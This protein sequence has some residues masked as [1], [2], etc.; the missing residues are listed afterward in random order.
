MQIRYLVLDPETQVDDAE[1]TVS[2]EEMRRYYQD[3]REDF[4]Q[5]S[6]AEVL[7]VEFSRTPEPE[8]SAA[9][10]ARARELRQ[11]LAMGANF[12][13]LAQEESADKASAASGG[14]LGWFERGDMAPEFEAAAFDL[15]IGALSEPVLT[16]FGYHLIKVT[17]REDERVRASHIL[18]PIQLRGESEDKL[19]AAVDRLERV[20][21]REGLQAAIDSTGAVSRQV[22]LVVDSDFVPGIGPFAPASDWASHDSTAVGDLSPVYETN[23]GFHVFELVERVPE[24][25]VP[26]LDAQA[27]IRRRL[28]LEKKKET[29]R[30]LADQ[31]ASELKQGATLESVASERNLSVQVTPLFTRLEFVPG[32][33]QANSVIGTAFGLQPNEIAGP[34]EAANQLYFIQV[35]ERVEPEREAFASAKEGLRARLIVQ[36]RQTAVEEWLREVR[37]QADIKDWRRQLFV[38]RS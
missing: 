30:R 16:N 28:T 32:I 21:L 4:L 7:L 15:G 11:Q 1:V 27:A 17:G 14:D 13:E 12:E 9:A 19:L 33:G 26:F 6:T 29:A 2:E 31:L 20:A 18:L 5:P 3:N 38:P 34:I 10:L 35:S 25:Y 22:M 37:E 8:D 24:S 23:E 36:R